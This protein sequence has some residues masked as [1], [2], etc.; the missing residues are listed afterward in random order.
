MFLESRKAMAHSYAYNIE[1]GIICK[2]ASGARTF[3]N[4]V[5]IYYTFIKTVFSFIFNKLVLGNL[6]APLLTNGSENNI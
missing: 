6:I 5:L 3:I 1:L 4:I 2:Y